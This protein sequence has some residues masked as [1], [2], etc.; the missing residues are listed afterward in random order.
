ME[1]EINRLTY[2][3]KDI[4]TINQNLTEKRNQLLVIIAGYKE[5]WVSCFSHIMKGWGGDFRLFIVLKNIKIQKWVVYEENDWR[6]GKDWTITMDDKTLK[7]FFW[8]QNMK[9]FP[10]SAR[11]IETL[12]LILRLNIQKEY[13]VFHHNLKVEKISTDDT[14]GTSF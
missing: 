8:K 13:S 7:I 14:V 12:L 5:A 2:A 10:S 4:S 1:T 11:D 3:L 9:L 6:F